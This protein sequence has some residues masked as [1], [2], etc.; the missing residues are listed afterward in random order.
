M[1]GDQPI[2]NLGCV[3]QRYRHTRRDDVAIAHWPCEKCGGAATWGGNR[4]FA[5]VEEDDLDAYYTSVRDKGIVNISG[6]TLPSDKVV[7]LLH[8][9]RDH[10]GRD[11]IRV[12]LARG[13]TVNGDLTLDIPVSRFATFDGA[14]FN[15]KTDLRFKAACP[16]NFDG[17]HFGGHAKIRGT[18]DHKIS[19]VGSSFGAGLEMRSAQVKS[20]A[21]FLSTVFGGEVDFWQMEVSALLFDKI[22][23]QHRANFTGLRTGIEAN[24]TNQIRSGEWFDEIAVITHDFVG[25]LIKAQDQFLKADP[26]AAGAR[27]DAVVF[28]DQVSFKYAHLGGD[29]VAFRDVRFADTVSFERGRLNA[30]HALIASSDIAKS[31]TI[32][33]ACDV[34]HC[35]ATTFQESVEL[36]LAAR[37]I[38]IEGCRFKGPSL[39][40][41]LPADKGSVAKEGPPR[42][43]SLRRT[44]VEHVRLLDLDLSACRFDGASNL[45]KLIIQGALSMTT[46]PPPALAARRRLI[47]EEWRWRN[48]VKGWKLPAAVTWQDEECKWSPELRPERILHPQEIEAQYRALRKGAEESKNEPGAADFYYGEMEMRRQDS[49]KPKAERLVLLLYWLT[50][51]Y[52]LRASR[53]LAWLLGVLIVATVLLATAGLKQPATVQATITGSPPNQTIRFQAPTTSPATTSLPARLGT[54]ALVAVE[55]AVFRTSDQQLTYVGRLIQAALRFA[56]PI[57]LGL[58]VLSIR[59]RVKR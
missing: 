1:A 15:G 51:G 27:Y 6:C 58:A 40:A 17:A 25:L 54:A 49:A 20:S 39:I 59:G 10:H 8:E 23:L 18:F 13:T 47:A 3:D 32:D 5:H 42:L 16:I 37:S 38:L 57:L 33:A 24:D 14:H 22:T 44:D 4:C 2:I 30:S 56:G 50:S 34:L 36:R 21:I 48:H 7:K 19:F 28:Q 11:S 9:A 55:G 12:L 29:E 41:S 52:A 35:D 43:L 46:P 31:V 26:V 45:D 53:A